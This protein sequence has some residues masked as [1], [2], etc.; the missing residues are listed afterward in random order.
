MSHFSLLLL[1]IGLGVGVAALLVMIGVVISRFR[2]E[3]VRRRYR[4]LHP[5]VERELGVLGQ[6]ADRAVS[7]DNRLGI[8]ITLANLTK[9]DLASLYTES[10]GAAFVMFAIV[11]AL[12]LRFVGVAAIEMV[13]LLCAPAFLFFGGRELFT[14]RIHSR[15]AQIRDDFQISFQNFLTMFR[16]RLMS[17]SDPAGAFVAI[18]ETYQY[19]MDPIGNRLLGEICRE[20]R[21]LPIADVL[22]YTGTTYELPTLTSLGM[23]LQLV[24]TSGM[25]AGTILAQQIHTARSTASRI[26]RVRLRTRAERIEFLSLPLM[27]SM[28]AL[29]VGAIALLLASSGAGGIL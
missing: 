10:L 25:T 20:V 28:M 11:F 9:D 1:L 18:Y 4:S 19:S 27:A 16:L 13:L 24:A 22:I 8:D 3:R 15:A 12:V 14:R 26:M 7:K 2:F 5:T 6:M 21:K 23:D 17:G 29:T